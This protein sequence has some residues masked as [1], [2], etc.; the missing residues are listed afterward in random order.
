MRIEL[1]TFR[2][3]CDSCNKV[4]I[5]QDVK[6]YDVERASLPDGWT[7]EESHGWGMTNYSRTEDLCPDCSKKNKNGS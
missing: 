2:L 7:Q 5:V 1:K 4:T 3:N 6:C